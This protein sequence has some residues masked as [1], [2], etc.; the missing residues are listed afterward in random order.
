MSAVGC[1]SIA[2]TARRHRRCVPRR[3][4][5]GAVGGYEHRRLRVG[6][7]GYCRPRSWERSRHRARDSVRET[8]GGKPLCEFC[9]DISDFTFVAVFL[10]LIQVHW[11][12][13]EKLVRVLAESS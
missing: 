2:L 9:R 10:T 6:C 12:D 7:K 11:D 1:A 4:S 8:G 13:P 5:F 3:E